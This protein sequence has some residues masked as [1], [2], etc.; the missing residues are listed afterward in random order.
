MVMS[1]GTP[2]AMELKSKF[3]V[4]LRVYVTPE[5]RT[6]KEL[7][8]TELL[9]RALVLAVMVKDEVMTPNPFWSFTATE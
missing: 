3:V 5:A 7:A 8:A 9:R 4:M 2:I 1:V 6:V